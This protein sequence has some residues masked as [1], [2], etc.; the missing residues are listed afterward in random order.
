ME[1]S[2]VQRLR[3]I[4]DYR[5]EIKTFV[6]ELRGSVHELAA[7]KIAQRYITTGILPMDEIAANRT[8]DC[9]KSLCSVP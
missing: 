8:M 4:Q 1:V 9:S 7:V 6:A 5:I 2:D 3:H